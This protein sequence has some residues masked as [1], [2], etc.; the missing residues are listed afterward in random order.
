MLKNIKN[1]AM[2]LAAIVIASTSAT[3]MSFNTSKNIEAVA[4]QSTVRFQFNGSS[5]PGAEAN[6]ANWDYAPSA[7]CG[8]QS[9]NAC[10]IEVASNLVS[11][12]GGVLKIDPAKLNTHYSTTTL[13]M[14]SDIDGTRP[15]PGPIYEDIDNRD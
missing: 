12:I 7:S 14:T 13:P 8:Y 11:T 10:V 3:L 1:Y 5:S 4:K 2:A 9:N 15:T 6:P